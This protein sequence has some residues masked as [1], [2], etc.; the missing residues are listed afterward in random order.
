MR[1]SEP[2]APVV[3][4]I[5]CLQIVCSANLHLAKFECNKL[6]LTATDVMLARKELTSQPQTQF[7]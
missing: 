1:S 2:W 3:C 7:W 6:G 4:D 5:I